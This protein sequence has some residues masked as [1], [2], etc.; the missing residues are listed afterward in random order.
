MKTIIYTVILTIFLNKCH[1]KNVFTLQSSTYLW[2][3]FRNA[4][5]NFSLT[6]PWWQWQNKCETSLFVLLFVLNNVDQFLF[7]LA[8][9]KPHYSS[10]SMADKI[11]TFII[12]NNESEIWY[13]LLLS[14]VAIKSLT[15][16]HCKSV[17][18][19]FYD[20]VIYRIHTKW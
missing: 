6:L 12:K 19:C 7:R 2:W 20:G 18:F 13:H 4:S 9:I 1:K 5:H 16:Q 11:F 15:I 3:I 17:R 8:H 10:S 14:F